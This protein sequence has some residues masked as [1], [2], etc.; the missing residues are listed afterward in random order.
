MR[1]PD[2]PI[3]EKIKPPPGEFIIV[4]MGKHFGQC[5]KDL[6]NWAIYL[7]FE[8]GSIELRPIMAA[9]MSF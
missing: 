2:L 3:I 6:K 5:Y 4:S 8:V 7:F 9:K 1:Q